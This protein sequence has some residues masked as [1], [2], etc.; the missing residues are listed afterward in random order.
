MLP[1]KYFNLGDEAIKPIFIIGA[2][3]SG[4]T[5]LRRILIDANIAIPP[6]SYVFWKVYIYFNCFQLLGWKNISRIIISC[7]SKHPEYYVW[8]TNLEPVFKKCLHLKKEKRNLSNIINLIYLEYSVQNQNNI[9]CWGD[10]TP[11]NTFYLKW[12]KKTFPHSKFINVIRD[13]RDVVSSYKMAKL[14]NISH[15]CWRWKKSLKITD[16]FEKKFPDSIINIKYENLVIKPRDTLKDIFNFIGINYLEKYYI[17]LIVKSKIEDVKQYDH[18]KKV[19]K[20]LDGKSIGKW[21]ENLNEKEKKF[22][23]LKIGKMLRQTGYI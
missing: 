8:K 3:R 14:S 11:M 12:I 16:Q 23:L 9:I 19:N 10:K 22:V 4:T 13:G 17:N 20:P 7:Y 18:L 15:T 5:L 21:R 6:E 2:G 1:N